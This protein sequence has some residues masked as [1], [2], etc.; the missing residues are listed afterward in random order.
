VCVC[1]QATSGNVVAGTGGQLL[2]HFCLSVGL[3]HNHDTSSFPLHAFAAA[4]GLNPVLGTRHSGHNHPTYTVGGGERGEKGGSCCTRGTTRG[5]CGQGRVCTVEDRAAES[6]RVLNP[7]PGFGIPASARR[8]H[9]TRPFQLGLDSFGPSLIKSPERE[10]RVTDPYWAPHPCRVWMAPIP[11]RCLVWLVRE[12]VKRRLES[13]GG[14]NTGGWR[15]AGWWSNVTP[16]PLSQILSF[17]RES[18]MI[19]DMTLQRR[20]G[21]IS[22]RCQCWCQCQ[23][24]QCDGWM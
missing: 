17:E 23:C 15:L 13:L 19:R 7:V 8:S 18:G 11:V 2:S 14:E 16:P 9:R 10:A 1:L 22:V 4:N 12:S 20:T 24:C 21:S 3:N 5:V 6:V